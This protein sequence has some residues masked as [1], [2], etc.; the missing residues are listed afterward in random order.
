LRRRGEEEEVVEEKVKIG[1]RKMHMR[2]VT[3]RLID[4]SS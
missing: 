3:I 1:W 4:S 2:N